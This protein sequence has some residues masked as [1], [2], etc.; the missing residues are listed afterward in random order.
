M[1]KYLLSLVFFLQTILIICPFTIEGGNNYCFRTFSPEGGFYYDGVKSIQQDKDGFIWIVMDNDLYRFDGYQYK[2]YYT[3]FKDKDISNRWQFNVITSDSLG[4]LLV[5][6]GNGLYQYNNSSDSFT[7]LLDQ[8]ITSINVDPHNNIWVSRAVV[9]MK[10]DAQLKVWSTIEYNGKS[11]LNINSCDG[12]KSSWFLSSGGG[13]IYEYNYSTKQIKLVFSFSSASYIQNIRKKGDNLWVLA[14]NQGLCKIDISTF[15]VVEQFDFFYQQDNEHILAKTFHI[16]KNEQIWICTQRGLYVLDPESKEY[17]LYLHSKS[18]PFSLPDNS[19]WTITEDNHQNLWIGTYSGGLS[20]VNL[21]EKVRFKSYNVALGQLNHDVVSSFAEDSQFLWVA[22]EGGGINRMDKQTGQFSFYRRG[23]GGNNLSYD[24]VKSVVMDDH[25]NLWIAMFRGG[26]DCYDMQSKCFTGFKREKENK[27]S[28]LSNDLRKIVL[29]PDSGLWIAYQLNRL[30]V[31]FFSF[32]EKTFTHYYFDDSDS[33]YF[34]YDIC[35]DLDGNLWIISHKKVYKMDAVTHSVEEVRLKDSFYP[36]AQT[37]SADNDNNIWIG[38]I[39]NGLIKYDTHTSSFNIY[40]DILKFNTSSIYSICADNENN[41]WMGTDN[42]LFRYSPEDNQFFRYDKKDGVQGQVYYP[43]S[44]FKSKDGSL[45]F[46]G[47]NGF[48][49]IN[50]REISSNKFKARVIITD[51]LVN[52]ISVKPNLEDSV[53]QDSSDSFP[54]EIILDYTQVN[55]GFKF[56][57]DN[58]LIPEKNR[59]KFRLKGYD[60]NWVEVDATSRSAFYSKVPPGN[61]T[62]EVLTANNDGIWNEAPALIKI[63][64]LP[65]PWLSWQAYILYFLMLAGITYLIFRYYNQQ[66][67]LKLQIY[68]DQVDKN[69]K[70]EIHQSQ[71]RFFTNISHDFRTPLSLILAALEKLR[72]DGLKEYYYHLLNNNAQRLLNLVNEL[73]DF[74]SVENGKMKLHIQTVDL[75]S[76][77][78]GLA[79]DF[80]D[81]ARQ[82]NIKFDVIID[83]QAS[84]SIYA[85]KQVMEKIIMNLLNNAFKYTKDGGFVGLE[86]YSAQNS[87]KSVHENSFTIGNNGEFKNSYAIAVRDSGIGISKDSIKS[88]FERFYKV[89]TVNFD[90]HLGTGIGLALVKSLVLLHKGSISIYSEREKGTDMVVS[91]SSDA[92]SYKDCDFIQD[93]SKTD[94]TIEVSVY[95]ETDRREEADLSTTLEND[96]LLRDKKRILIVEDNEDLRKLIAESLLPYYEVE[97]A[98]NG[99]IGFNLLQNMEIDLVVSDIMM[100]QMDGI[101]LCRK[102]KDDINISH[103]PFI[104]LTAKTGLESKIEGADSGADTYF[105]KPLDLNLLRLT[106]QNILKRQQQLKEYYAKNYF[107]DS[108]EL[109]TNQQ[110][111]KFL[112]KFVE[113]LDQN[114]DQPEMDVNYIASQLSMSRSKLYTKVK[115]MTDKSIVEFILSY[116]LRKAAR[117]IVEEDVSM[118]D[119]MERIGIESQSYFTRAF[120]KEFGDTPTAFAAKQKK[121]KND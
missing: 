3:Y 76:F 13:N 51:F 119:V 22:T 66:K 4:R 65:A 72:L 55:F 59:F 6:T 7:K 112:K 111:N 114:I 109:S 75:K 104:L 53:A 103:I 68:L 79:F 9:L 24:N 57:S 120:K 89:K 73:M 54:D 63:K 29:E 86:V 115:S 92:D 36:N 10:Y 77:I 44:S 93:E 113:I 58:Y 108:A 34:I 43:L 62:F 88:V 99:L 118:R 2:R 117:L 27:E 14:T 50:S 35:R 83:P 61:Y 67:K 45:Y 96:I 110:D 49:W 121:G 95:R 38:T 90:A 80:E 116:R 26:L 47:S 48:T 101:T 41:M 28:L 39:G 16:D 15:E 18:E 60:D 107:V 100:P 69:K 102:V 52:N 42:G 31:S 78:E 87:F 25:Q 1:R 20:Y 5:G 8:N 37:I 97:Q 33:Y 106:I 30:V 74:R 71:L 12:D 40:D 70:E 17:T 105:E 56:S 23:S 91:F 94:D 84:A 82:R 85:D 21:D 81:Y 98:A 19:I 11:I 64:R 32:K 46:G